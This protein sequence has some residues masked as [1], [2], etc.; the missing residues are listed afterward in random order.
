MWNCRIIVWLMVN[1]YWF[2]ELWLVRMLVISY[3]RFLNRLVIAG[4]PVRFT[5]GRL[6]VAC[7][8]MRYLRV[9]LRRRCPLLRLLH[10]RIFRQILI[11]H[12]TGH[13]MLIVLLIFI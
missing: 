8:M 3:S 2:I 7:T 1:Y 13:F 11:R 9:D 6:L 10:R 5:T 12:V 4:Y